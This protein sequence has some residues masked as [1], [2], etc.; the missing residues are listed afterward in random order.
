MRELGVGKPVRRV[1]DDQLIRG[2]GNYT[3]DDVPN[4]AA[5]MHVVRS[6]HAAAKIAG[7]NSTEARAKSGVLA[8]LTADDLEHMNIQPIGSKVPYARAGGEPYLAT[9]Y[10]PLAR[11]QV[12]YPGDAVAIVI[13]ESPG[14][15]ADAA[16]LV[17]VDY[18][19]TD[20]VT[21][22]RA[23]TAESALRVWSDHPDNVCFAADCG[24]ADA[25]AEAFDKADRIVEATYEIS[26][27]ATVSMEPRVATGSFD[28][29]SGRY[30]LR[31]GLQMPHETGR[32][33]A[34]ALG[35]SPH[36]VHVISP[37]VGGGFGMKLAL[38]QE[39]ILVLIA[40]RITSRPVR[41]MSTRSE[42]FQSDQQA[43]DNVSKVALALDAH[44]QFLALRV[45]TLANLGAYVGQWSL[46]VPGGNVGGLAGPY[47]IGAFDVSVTGV[48]TNS[49]P[50]GPFRGAGRPE[51][52]YCIERIVDEAAR[53]MNID[54]A[55]LRRRNLVQPDAMPYDTG[56]VFTYDSGDFPA[57][58]DKTLAAS[59][60][61]G[62]AA[63][64]EASER[65]G[66]L[67]GRGMAFVIESAGGPAPRAF[68]EHVELRFDTSGVC[69]VMAG[70]H[71]H[72]QGHETVYRQLAAEHLGMP[73]DQVRVIYGDTQAV[74]HGRGSFGS[75]TMMAGGAAF[76]GAA[77]KIVEKGRKFAAHFMEVDAAE[78]T[79]EEGI[80]S[81]AASN[82][83]MTMSEVAQSSYIPFILA[84]DMEVG[85]WAS[86]ASSGGGITF[87]N[88]CHISEVE[89]DP[90]TGTTAVASY[91]VTED[92]G[93][94]VNPLLLEG[95][96]QGGVAQGL[97]Q[98]LMERIVVDPDSGQQLTGSL[99]DY[100]LPRADHINRIEVHSHPVPTALNPMG[101]KGA[102]EA[103]CV[104]ALPAVS[105]A[106]CDAL[107]REGAPMPD[108]PFSPERVWR[109]LSQA[110][111]KRQ[112]A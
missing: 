37:D 25:C 65:A 53:Q 43:R 5:F 45:K 38:Y 64:R 13:A 108:M 1:E 31:A 58:L 72:G 71:S 94:V 63:R 66:K 81:H 2:F 70:S 8:V 91:T 112:S 90:A 10:L 88:A 79:F 29:R 105:N 32:D 50:V 34:G 80:F 69:S 103:G 14:I 75:R 26:R 82:K 24:D 61:D 85:L 11:G 68:D 67:R 19:L 30:T 55:E 33:I 21:D 41:W 9:P 106:V 6:P 35:I 100:A 54:P 46:H 51:A 28:R 84:E 17:E 89:I 62:F 40:S 60:W 27:I 109:A 101:S 57:I 22:V 76:I 16:E 87:P 15:A 47:T 95:Q 49:V 39:Y 98:A 86:C 12:A 73:F 48:L 92:V 97:G 110:N 107:A 36:D 78:I 104:G 83:S 102:G 77:Q 18:E 42:S 111:A 4:A 59:D 96:I 44:G 23:A 56:L 7:V 99:L 52:S 74:T 20:F 3:D 93:N